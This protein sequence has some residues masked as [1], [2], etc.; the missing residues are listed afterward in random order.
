M[1]KRINFKF[2]LRLCG[3]I[4][5]M[6]LGAFALIGLPLHIA[7]N[8]ILG[9]TSIIFSIIL[10]IDVFL[11]YQI[12]I[13][14]ATSKHYGKVIQYNDEFVTLAFDQYTMKNGPLQKDFQ[15]DEFRRTPKRDEI[16]QVKMIVKNIGKV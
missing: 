10:F 8:I 15:R 2:Y 1:K 13:T 3:G 7:A 11:I 9:L 12:P 14:I 4:I 16:V 6:S 5:L